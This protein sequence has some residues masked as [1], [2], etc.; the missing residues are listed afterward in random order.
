MKG[1]EGLDELDLPVTDESF[2]L[3]IMN[4]PFTRPTNHE[5]TTVPVP[6]FAGFDT[7]KAEQK[8]MSA[9][10][11]AV[12]G[13][14]RFGHGNAGLASNFMDHRP[15]QAE[16]GR[17]PSSRAAVCLCGGGIVGGCP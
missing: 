8:A 14:C 3:V 5:S 17:H 9:R 6:S 10:L 1:V 16:A 15:C 4:P 12:S 7:S 13:S 11:K 2:D